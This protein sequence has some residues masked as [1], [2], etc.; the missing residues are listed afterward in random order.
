[1]TEIHPAADRA[2][3]TPVPLEARHTLLAAARSPDAHLANHQAAR[4]GLACFGEVEWLMPSPRPGTPAPESLRI[5]AWNVQHGHFPRASGAL[6]TAHDVDIALLSELDIGMRRSSQ[7]HVPRQIARAQHC[8]YAFALEFLELT[9][10]PDPTIQGGDQRENFSGFHGNGLT[11]QLTP[12]RFALIHLPPEADWYLEPRRG[13]YR[14]GGRLALAARVPLDTG[15][16]VVA[17]THLESD[18]DA[19]GRARQMHALLTGLDAFAQGDPVLI[20]GDFNTGARTPDFD[21]R[22]ESLFELARQSGYDWLPFN[23]PGPTSRQSLVTNAVQQN[24][25]RYD[26]FFGRGLTASDPVTIPA[27]DG[28]TPLSDHDMIAVTIQRNTR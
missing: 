10:V 7:Q 24:C 19:A 25:A 5:A 1:M 18:T 12:E 3:L 14:I 28:T 16:V 27:L 11:T 23:A 26:W 22:T 2:L 15:H 13:Q 20:G 6:L 17:T 21:Y 9:S 8:G 4:A